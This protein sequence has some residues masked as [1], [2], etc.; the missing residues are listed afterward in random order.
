MTGKMAPRAQAGKLSDLRA[1]CSTSQ[2]P[3]LTPVHVPQ[4]G[5]RYDGQIAVFGAGLQENLGHK[6]YLLV[7]CGVRRGARWE[8]QAGPC[9]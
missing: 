7:S 4:R 8:G 5:C 2:W 9:G 6:R 3:S 1:T